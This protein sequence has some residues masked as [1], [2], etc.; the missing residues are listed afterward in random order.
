MKAE[1]DLGIY[2]V[3]FGPDVASA[4]AAAAGATPAVGIN[5]AVKSKRVR[6][7]KAC[8]QCCEYSF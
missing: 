1:E 3:P 2:G 5:P 7:A 6:V 8:D 4:A